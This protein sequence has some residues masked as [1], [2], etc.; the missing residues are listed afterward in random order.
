MFF[1]HVSAVQ[2]LPTRW[3]CKPHHVCVH[4][5]TGFCC[6][7]GLCPGGHARE[8][9]RGH[10]ARCSVYSRRRPDRSCC[11]M[12]GPLVLVFILMMPGS[13]RPSNLVTPSTCSPF[14]VWSVRWTTVI[15]LPVPHLRSR[16]AP[17]IAWF[18]YHVD[19]FV[20]RAHVPCLLNP[21]FKGT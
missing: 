13:W 5:L 14:A 20:C 15:K 1:R 8:K 4:R 3:R 18:C 7:L 19:A 10:T 17:I 21:L 2:Q 9:V 11:L 12:G 16:Y 6:S